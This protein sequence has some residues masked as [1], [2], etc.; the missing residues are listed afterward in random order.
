MIGRLAEAAWF[1][2][3]DSKIDY[4]LSNPNDEQRPVA[5]SPAVVLCEVG[6]CGANKMFGAISTESVEVDVD[7]Q[8]GDTTQQG[9]CDNPTGSLPCVG[10]EREGK[11]GSRESK[12]RRCRILP[13]D[14]KERQ[15]ASTK[16]PRPLAD[17]RIE[18]QANAPLP[19]ASP[20]VTSTS[21]RRLR[22]KS[23]RPAATADSPAP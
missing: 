1:K 14:G 8:S 2:S 20:P 16:N 15:G 11:F 3:T 10:A 19:V 18:F 9:G 21:G 12:D 22:S 23:S 13:T 4:E 17:L 7:K 6:N 5:V